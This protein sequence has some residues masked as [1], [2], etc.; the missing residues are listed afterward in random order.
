MNW[1]GLA[2][3]I[4]GGALIATG[5]GAP[6]GSALVGL[7]AT[8]GPAL[9]GA[10][11]NTLAADHAR[12]QQ[13]Q[14][15]DQAQGQLSQAF[16]P[17]TSLG[18]GA[19]SLLARG[20]GIDMPTSGGAP[21][22]GATPLTADGPRSVYTDPNRT[23]GVLGSAFPNQFQPTS[24]TAPATAPPPVSPLWQALVQRTSSYAGGR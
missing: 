12:N 22:A 20:L 2:E 9:I 11:A 1:L 15:I 6:A 7:A 8:A 19:A 14:A 4:G 18:S 21:A 3:L 17:Y 5:I 16:S 13:T 24:P 10:G 23:W